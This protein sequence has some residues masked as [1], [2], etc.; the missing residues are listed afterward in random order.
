MSSKIIELE[1]L[2]T[3]VGTTLF[4]RTFE[5]LVTVL[6]GTFAPWERM[7]MLPVPGGTVKLTTSP[8]AWTPRVV[9]WN[10]GGPTWAA[11]AGSHAAVGCGAVQGRPSTTF[12][13]GTQALDRAQ[14]V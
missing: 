5:P 6:T 11:C 14:Q 8:T 12:G 2:V 9:A 1:G 7:L 13:A 10:T 3:C 4:G